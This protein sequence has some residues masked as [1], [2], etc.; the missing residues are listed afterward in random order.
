MYNISNSSRIEKT[1]NDD[2]KKMY[3]EYM[4]KGNVTEQGIMKLFMEQIDP[5]TCQHM[6]NSK[7]ET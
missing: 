7:D 4:T 1:V 6:I 2:D 5:E 3:G